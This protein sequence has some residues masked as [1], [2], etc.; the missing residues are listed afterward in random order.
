MAVYNGDLGDEEMWCRE[1]EASAATGC[2]CRGVAV[3]NE[4]CWRGVMIGRGQRAI[5][6]VSVLGLGLDW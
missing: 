3:C 1:E 5:P 2:S 6:I 4:L